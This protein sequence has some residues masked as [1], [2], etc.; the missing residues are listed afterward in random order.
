MEM[1][2]FQQNSFTQIVGCK[3][4]FNK[5]IENDI[6][7]SFFEDHHEVQNGYQD[8]FRGARVLK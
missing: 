6:K 5:I 7:T 8:D 3:E 2:L 1:G 4:S